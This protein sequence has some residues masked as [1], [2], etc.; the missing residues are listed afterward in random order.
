MSRWEA[1]K[2]S[3]MLVGFFFTGVLFGIALM[4][5]RIYTR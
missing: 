4:A 2:W 5:L 1:V 3:L